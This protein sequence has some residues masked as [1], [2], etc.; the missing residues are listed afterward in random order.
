[1]IEKL[2]LEQEKCVIKHAREL[3]TKLVSGDVKLGLTDNNRRGAEAAAST[4]L[5]L[6]EMFQKTLM[7]GGYGVRTEEGT[8]SNGRS[9]ILGNGIRDRLGECGASCQAP[10]RKKDHEG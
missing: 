4:A 5:E 9:D 6:A 3:F 10:V 7:E 1:M 8:G 2:T